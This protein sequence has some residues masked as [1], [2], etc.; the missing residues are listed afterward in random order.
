MT[1]ARIG[2]LTNEEYRRQGMADACIL[3]I[4]GNA[5]PRLRLEEWAH[6]FGLTQAE[7]RDAVE[8]W[9]AAQFAANGVRPRPAGRLALPDSPPSPRAPKAETPAP[10]ELEPAEMEHADKVEARKAARA[11]ATAAAKRERHGGPGYGGPCKCPLKD[12]GLPFFT[13]QGLH[14]H[15]RRDHDLTRAAADELLEA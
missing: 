14:A 3:L 6:Y 15:L 8:R 2:R 4:T 9:K 7:V 5:N 1:S 13:R 12:C 11:K 10:A